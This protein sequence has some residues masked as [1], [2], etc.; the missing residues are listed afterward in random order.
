M[1]IS[2]TQSRESTVKSENI[3]EKLEMIKESKSK[4]ESK[5]VQGDP[6][7]IEESNR[8][9]T[10]YQQILDIVTGKLDKLLSVPT[11]IKHKVKKEKL[12]TILKSTMKMERRIMMTTMNS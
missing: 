2:L 7:A 1:P 4:L 11:T 6:Y 12:Q 10:D 3:D 9:I 5:I 8:L